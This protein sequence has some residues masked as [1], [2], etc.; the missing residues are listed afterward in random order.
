MFSMF[1]KNSTGTKRR[2]MFSM[3]SRAKT[4]STRMSTNTLTPDEE[5]DV[6]IAREIAKLE[7]EKKQQQ[8]LERL[9]QYLKNQQQEQEREQQDLKILQKDAERQQQEMLAAMNSRAPDFGTDDKLL[10]E[11]NNL[12][13]NNLELNNLELNNLAGTRKKRKL[14]KH[15]KKH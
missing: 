2:G 5:A 11:L 15:K 8:E 13:L 4:P 12:E 9:Q 10:E 7:E 6:D 1:R 3:F 14:K